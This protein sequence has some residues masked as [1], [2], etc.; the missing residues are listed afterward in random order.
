MHVLIEREGRTFVKRAE[1]LKD[2]EKAKCILTPIRM[3]IL[4]ILAQKPRHASEIARILREQEQKIYYHMKALE[5]IG[6]IKVVEKIE[7][8]GTTAK[9]YALTA[10]TF[11]ID[12]PG[13]EERLFEQPGKALNEKVLKFFFPHVERGRLNSTIV[14]G[15][16][17]P[18]GPYQVRARDGHYAVELAYFLGSYAPS[19]REFIVKLDADVKA[20]RAWDRNLILIGGVL[21]NVLT[22]EINKYMPVRFSQEAFPFRKICSEITGR[23]YED[24]KCGLIAKIPNPFKENC[25][26]LVFAGTRYVGTKAAV[27]A[28]TKFHEKVLSDYEGEEL[29]CRVVKGLDMDGDGKIDEVEILE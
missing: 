12:L 1:L 14:V 27:L 21:T 10:S 16:P 4:E 20:E 2:P 26:I 13:G 22:G 19:S 25:S 18:H 15:S 7:K 24:E 11:V 6:A 3:K 28:I 23:E 9:V 5:K 17:D 8:R 29:W